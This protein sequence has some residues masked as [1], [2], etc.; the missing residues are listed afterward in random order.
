MPIDGLTDTQAHFIEKYVTI[1]KHRK[2]A[3]Y[4]AGKRKKLYR[5]IRHADDDAEAIAARKEVAT[6]ERHRLMAELAAMIELVKPDLVVADRHDPLVDRVRDVYKE[7]RRQIEAVDESQKYRKARDELREIEADMVA[8][9]NDLLDEITDTDMEGGEPL[10]ELAAGKSVVIWQRDLGADLKAHAGGDLDILEI[11]SGVLQVYLNKDILDAFAEDNDRVT[12]QA[13]ADEV[14]KVYQSTLSACKD[15]LDTLVPVRQRLV[16]EIAHGAG[17]DDPIGYLMDGLNRYV[18][19]TI[20]PEIAAAATD[21]RTKIDAFIKIRWKQV[22]A[23]H[24]TQK[25]RKLKLTLKFALP[26]LGIAVAAVGIGVGVALT[27]TGIGTVAGVGITLASVAILRGLLSVAKNAYEELASIR[28]LTGRLQKDLDS[29]ADQYGRAS[30]ANEIGA[31]I[32]NSFVAWPVMKCL[33]AAESR[34]DEIEMR[35]AL[36]TAN[37]NKM[38]A[39]AERAMVALEADREALREEMDGVS[40]KELDRLVRP[41]GNEIDKTLTKISDLGAKTLPLQEAFAQ[42]RQKLEQLASLVS[43]KVKVA[44]MIIPIV[45]E[46]AFMVA[47][48]SVG[49]AGAATAATAVEQNAGAAVALVGEL[50]DG[51]SAIN[52]AANS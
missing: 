32:V 44:T 15:M 29:L 14:E 41:T 38:L 10:A 49:L 39:E 20:T 22:T 23:R 42:I 17:D 52:T 8:G 43:A 40:E 1:G 26:V 13:L 24:K 7:Y 37:Q 11:G 30:S 35:V 6:V 48:V 18:S 47:N 31:A 2:D 16:A 25:R 34:M 19:T 5:E 46:L 50:V 12:P 28:T 3:D 33:P 36:V 27:T 21:L 45:T 51:A 4:V 9:F